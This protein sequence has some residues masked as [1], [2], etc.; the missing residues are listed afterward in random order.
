MDTII[1]G[2]GEIGISNSAD[3]VLKTFALGPCVAI[4]VTAPGTRTSI[5]MHIA[6]P[7]SSINPELALQKPGYFADTGISTLLS[8]LRSNNLISPDL[9]IKLAG[10]SSILDHNQIFN[11]GERNLSAIKKL[12]NQ[13]N[14]K[15]SAADTGG[16]HSRTVSLFPI[17]G[18]VLISSE[19]T[20]INEL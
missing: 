18:K 19:M 2:V 7:E 14:L 16:S 6:L 20:G 4:I 10:G 12:L 9:I 1:V 11:I 17:N 5:L 15:I 8:M 13:H 3:A